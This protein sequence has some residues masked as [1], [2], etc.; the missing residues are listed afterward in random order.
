MLS[1]SRCSFKE[2]LPPPSTKDPSIL[3]RVSWIYLLNSIPTIIE[4]SKSASKSLPNGN[5][6]VAFYNNYVRHNTALLCRCWEALE[7]NKKLIT[8][9]QKD[10]QK[11]LMSNFKVFCDKLEPMVST[12]K[13]HK[14][15][16]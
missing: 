14:R 7:V 12:K 15:S 6:I 3:Q 16:R 4:D 8:E 2:V 1:Y 10:Y 11:E 5:G 9:E 13:R